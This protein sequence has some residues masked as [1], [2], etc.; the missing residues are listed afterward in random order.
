MKLPIRN[1]LSIHQAVAAVLVAVVLG[2]AFSFIQMGIDY[3]AE[4]RSV[5][6][7]MTQITRAFYQSSTHASFNYG[8]D[9]AGQVVEGVFEFLPVY[10]ARIIDENGYLLAGK[11]RPLVKS[12]MRWL[13]EFMFGDLCEYNAVLYHPSRKNTVGSLELKVDSVVITQHFLFRSTVTLLSGFLRNLLLASVLSVVFFYMLS[14]PL[15]NIIKKVAGLDTEMLDPDSLNDVLPKKNDELHFLVTHIQNFLLRLIEYRKNSTALTEKIQ[16]QADL[17]SMTEELTHTGSWWFDCENGGGAFSTYETQVLGVPIDQDA[18]LSFYL[19]CVHVDDQSKVKQR[20][21]YLIQSEDTYLKHEYRLQLEG[22]I[23][24]DIIATVQVVRDIDR[25]A[26]RLVG[27]DRDVTETK[28][29]EMAL[30]QTQ[31]LNAIGKMAGGLA[32]DFNNLLGIIIGNLD[33][34]KTQIDAEDKRL[35]HVDASFRAAKRGEDLVNKLLAFS[36]NENHAKTVVD[37]NGVVGELEQ[38]LGRSIP[39]NIQVHYVLGLDL[40][41]SEIDGGDLSDAL[42]N[43]MSNACD[44]MPEGGDVFVVTT[45]I[46]LGEHFRLEHPEVVPGEYVQIKVKDCGEGMSLL[47]KERMFEPFYSTKAAGK[48]T[49]LGLSMVYGFVQRSNGF[50]D[51]KSIDTVAMEQPN[52]GAKALETGT[53]ISL[54]LPRSKGAPLLQQRLSKNPSRESYEGEGRILLID[55]EEELLFSTKAI[56]EGVGYEVMTLAEAGRAEMML[57]AA[58]P[59]DL[60]ICDV[61][62]PGDVNGYEIGEMV[63]HQYPETKFMLTSGYDED[64]K[65]WAEGDGREFLPKPYQRD[66]LLGKVKALIS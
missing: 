47:A 15:N 60:V 16:S 33:F 28:Q 51:V 53:S 20:F 41:F 62:M 27:A 50:V 10:S 19:S 37:V 56:L 5:K 4:R 29:I 52:K 8:Y 40:W 61:V 32:H 48:G 43:L 44:A 25:R 30:N 11:E 14:R 26:I 55:D 12:R 24:K 59:F 9:L 46:V 1:R 31:R 7:E 63:K 34:L 36:R 2:A 54:Y 64:I 6:E 45:N 22:G 3:V 66:V 39:K 13:A 23:V 42:Y 18:S 49:G 21:E 35:K 17:L 58:G 38:L 65:T 57:Q